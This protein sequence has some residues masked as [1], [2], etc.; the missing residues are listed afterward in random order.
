MDANEALTHVKKLAPHARLVK[1]RIDLKAKARAV[2]SLPAAQ[3][4]AARLRDEAERLR[5][6]LLAD[7]EYRALRA[8]EH[9][10]RKA[11]SELAGL[12]YADRYAVISP[13]TGTGYAI[14]RGDTL[15]ETIDRLRQWRQGFRS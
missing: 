4:E 11:E 6:R 1:Y 2:E 7:P 12:A 15:K 5:A 13:G 3:A 10:A 9:A 14:A 8:A